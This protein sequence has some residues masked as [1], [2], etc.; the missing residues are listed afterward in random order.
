MEKPNFFILGAPKCGTTSLASWLACHPRVFFSEPKEPNFFNTDRQFIYRPSPRAYRRL[1]K[2]AEPR[3]LAV[4]EGSTGYLSSGVALPAILDYTDAPRFI[5]C[6][7]NPID[8]VVSWHGQAIRMGVENRVTFEDA[9]R[10]Q[11]ARREGKHI[12]L[13]CKDPV[14]LQYRFICSLGTQLERV[15]QLVPKQD[16]VVVVLDDMK[17]DPMKEYRRVVNF[18]GVGD[19]GRRSFPVMNPAVQ[20]PLGLAAT[21]NLVTL[22]KRRLRI[23]R[24]FGLIRWAERRLK[25]TG[26][27]RVPSPE[28]L[29]ELH[30]A[31]RPEIQLLSQLLDRDCS[32]WMSGQS[33]PPVLNGS[34]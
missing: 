3:H 34:R 7:R 10:L 14:V 12:P 27:N 22:L 24:R 26:P 32:P 11:A 16:V 8:M 19:D 4:G 13:L 21:L 17:R 15:F 6:V 5:V 20:V 28:I 23:R 29:A 18:L 31:F 25:T 2:N 1:F 9:W 30:D 33:L